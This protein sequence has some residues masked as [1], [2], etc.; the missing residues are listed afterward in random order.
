MTIAKRMSSA[1]R[2][3]N[4]ADTLLLWPRDGVPEDVVTTASYNATGGWRVT[5]NARPRQ[6]LARARLGAILRR[7][8]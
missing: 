2:L 6:L 8:L 1:R 4:P 7:K 5:L 3:A